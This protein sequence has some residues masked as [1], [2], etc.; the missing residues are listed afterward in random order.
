MPGSL[1]RCVYSS[2]YPSS[3]IPHFLLQASVSFSGRFP[4]R[5]AFVNKVNQSALKSLASNCRPHSQ[6]VK[7]GIKLWSLA[8]S[9]G[10][11]LRLLCFT[12]SSAQ[13]M[14]QHISPID[15]VISELLSP[16]AHYSFT[17]RNVK[18]YMDNLYSS[19]AMFRLM[20]LRG[21]LA[22]GTTRANTAG[23]PRCWGG[24]GR[25]NAGN[26][27]RLQ[28]R[29]FMTGMFTPELSAV[30]WKDASPGQS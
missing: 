12:K 29:G 7:R 21:I 8:T 5:Q 10:Y 15:S 2:V 25:G 13:W 1:P 26:L 23:M 4:Y 24:G 17:E 30:L 16:N 9:C 14:T 19:P 3:Q 18:V 27:A 28:P 6:P 22:T 11:Q 20:Y